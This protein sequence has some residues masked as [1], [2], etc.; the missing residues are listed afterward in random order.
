[1]PSFLVHG[2]PSS[3]LTYTNLTAII[4]LL[5]TP[6]KLPLGSLV[7]SYDR[8]NGDYVPAEQILASHAPALGRRSY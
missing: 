6:A 1:M 4:K 2:P 7:A 3:H 8:P 5:T